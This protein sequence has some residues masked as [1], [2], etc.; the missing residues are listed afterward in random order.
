MSVSIHLNEED[1]V[2]RLLLTPTEAATALGIG[3]TKLYEL[4]SSGQ[5]LSLRIDGCRRIP[6]AAVDAFVDELM[7]QARAIHMPSSG[8][9]YPTPTS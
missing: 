6:R 9:P 2:P 8:E 1:D 4:I 3:R 7:E 5:L